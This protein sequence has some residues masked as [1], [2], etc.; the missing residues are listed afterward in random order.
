MFEHVQIAIKEIQIQQCDSQKFGNG[1]CHRKTFT[2]K[3]S[4][5]SRLAS[6]LWFSHNTSRM[7]KQLHKN[8]V[9][10]NTTMLISDCTMMALRSEYRSSLVRVD[11][12]K[13]SGAWCTIWEWWDRHW[14]VRAHLWPS[15]LL[16][17]F[18][19]LA[20]SFLLLDVC[21]E[22]RNFLWKQRH[23]MHDRTCEYQQ[24][25]IHK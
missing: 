7:I 8:C 10:N 17:G 12:C 20:K 23:S 22:V 24:S 11:V 14:T 18:H 16:V 1:A 9:N 13:Q 2:H 15:F 3:H 4:V 19:V 6:A 25:R 21:S 5:N